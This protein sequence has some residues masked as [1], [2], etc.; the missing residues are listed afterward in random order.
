[1]SDVVSTCRSTWRRLGVS[2]GARA[3][4]E[5]ELRSHLDAAAD[6]GVDVG[7]VVGNDAQGFA[8]EWALA[9]GLVRQRWRVIGSV[10]AAVVAS[11]GWQLVQEVFGGGQPFLIQREWPLVFTAVTWHLTLPAVFGVAVYLRATRDALTVRTVALALLASPVAV[12]VTVAAIYR[13]GGGL[14]VTEGPLWYSLLLALLIGLV[15]A[16]IVAVRR[17]NS[18]AAPPWT[19]D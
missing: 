2:A 11:A 6:G 5:S 15:R 18:P 1:V 4:L 10:L 8:S 9:R 19:T 14:R 17:R 16:A 12:W 3:D 7:T 13:R